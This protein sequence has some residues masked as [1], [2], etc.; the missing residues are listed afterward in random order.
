MVYYLCWYQP[1]R[2]WSD[3]LYSAVNTDT[4]LWKY[5]LAMRKLFTGRI[6]RVMFD[7]KQL[8]RTCYPLRPGTEFLFFDLGYSKA[9][10]THTQATPPR[11]T[12]PYGLETAYTWQNEQQSSFIS[13]IKL[14]ESK[15]VDIYKNK[16]WSRL[17]SGWGDARKDIK[18]SFET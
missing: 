15:C 12:P 1:Q 2:F 4:L 9:R 14:W 18:A 3:Y 8:E 6:W 5:A 7:Y 16:R 17:P 11:R 10:Q 13:S